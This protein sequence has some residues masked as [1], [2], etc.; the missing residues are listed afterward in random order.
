MTQTI[1]KCHSFNNKEDFLSFSIWPYN[2]YKGLI[3]LDISH[4]LNWFYHRNFN[5]TDDIFSGLKTNLPVFSYIADSQVS[6]D[7]SRLDINQRTN[8]FCWMLNAVAHRFTITSSEKKRERKQMV[9]NVSHLTLFRIWFSLLFWNAFF[10]AVLKMLEK[11][12]THLFSV[13]K[14]EGWACV[15]RRI[16][17]RINKQ[18]IPASTAA[19]AQFQVKLQL[20]FVHIV[21]NECESVCSSL[22]FYNLFIVLFHG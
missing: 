22:L 8:V 10:D 13:I 4:S 9:V 18:Q 6:I 2:V 21:R 1:H 12:A 11:N 3:E 16:Y 19:H 15:H 5:I 17:E 7:A 14:K 20:N